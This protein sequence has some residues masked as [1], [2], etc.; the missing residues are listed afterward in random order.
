MLESAVGNWGYS[1]C[2]ALL[3]ISIVVDPS[4]WSGMRGTERAALRERMD[5]HLLDESIFMVLGHT[6]DSLSL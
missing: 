5:A 1:P 3:P 4:V 6:L 2:R